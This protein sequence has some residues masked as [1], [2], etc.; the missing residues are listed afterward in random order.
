[1]LKKS[2]GPKQY[3]IKT[4]ASVELLAKGM[5]F[6]L[7]V[8]VAQI[9]GSLETI[10]LFV[11][12]LFFFSSVHGWFFGTLEYTLIPILSGLSQEKGRSAS[13]AVILFVCGTLFILV[14]FIYPNLN[15]LFSTLTSFDSE[16][17]DKF[18]KAFGYLCLYLFTSSVFTV[19]E[20][21]LN[22]Q[23]IYLL[24]SVLKGIVNPFIIVVIIYSSAVSINNY[25]LGYFLSHAI[26]LICL[27]V[28]VSYSKVDTPS[29]ERREV[30]DLAK[31]FYLRGYP[32]L[33]ASII[34]SAGEFILRYFLSGF[35]LGTLF[36]YTIA[37]KLVLNFNSLFGQ[38]IIKYGFIEVCDIDPLD[39]NERNRV[40][41]L[42][43]R[44]IY[45]FSCAMTAFL[46]SISDKL[47][48][49]FYSGGAISPDD[50][51]L[52]IAVFQ[53]LVF[54]ITPLS[55]HAFHWKFLAYLNHTQIGMYLALPSTLVTG[56]TYYF[57][58]SPVGLAL[59]EISLA[60][61]FAIVY[62]VYVYIK[63]ELSLKLKDAFFV[64]Y[65]LVICCLGFTL[66]ERLE[67]IY[68]GPTVVYLGMA[69]V[70]F[71]IFLLSLVFS[72]RK[73]SPFAFADLRVFEKKV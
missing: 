16:L 47:V 50:T 60:Y 11:W 53:L 70:A 23:R 2:I 35:N 21:I 1:M 49:L 27:I 44:S 59:A 45:L 41:A 56:L 37:Q 72:A 36:Y 18:S 55:V 8:V 40:Y 57:A 34:N 54:G 15:L 42:T 69:C 67:L 30:F 65:V 4:L 24:P 62:Y 29:L 66:F 32:L 26:V 10:D 3:S 22:Q 51:E 68:K 9:Y 31:L 17:V 14:C 6:F 25:A 71:V 7:S 20:I 28:V 5:I 19:L 38:T 39:V 46:L 13:N 12:S 48:A 64:L 63:A 61:F 43:V 52:V 58:T 73:I 33:A